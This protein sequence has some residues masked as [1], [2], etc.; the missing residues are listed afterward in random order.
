MGHQEHCNQY[1]YLLRVPLPYHVPIHYRPEGFE[2]GGAAVLVVQVVGVFPDVEGEEGLEAVGYRIV[3]T[4]TLQ[5]NKFT[6]LL[7]R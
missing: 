4:R 6:I 5:D 2:V 1:K 3:G 7:G